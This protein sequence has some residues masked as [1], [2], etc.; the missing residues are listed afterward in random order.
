MLP[1]YVFCSILGG[2][3]LLLGVL[4]NM[5]EGDAALDGLSD[6]SEALN[7]DVSGGVWKQAL[8]FRTLAY[9]IAVFGASGWVLSAIGT[10]APLT[11]I[12]AIGTALGVSAI[13]ASVMGYVQSSESGFTRGEEQFVG[14]PGRMAIP[15]SAQT[16]IGEV[17]VLHNGRTLSLRARAHAADSAGAQ[18][19]RYVVVVAMRDGVADVVPVTE[20]D[21]GQMGLVD[22]LGSS[23]LPGTKSD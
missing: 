5:F 11:G 20:E 17:S 14:A 7:A 2:G 6:A 15:F 3:L 23:R 22:G 9:G 18:D 4:G 10:S 19:W 1:I 8:S 12:L 21:A 16:G 13:V